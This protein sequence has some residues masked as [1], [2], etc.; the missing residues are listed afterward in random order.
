MKC[1]NCNYENDKAAKVCKKC[2]TDLKEKSNTKKGVNPLVIIIPVVAVL[3]LILVGVML[4]IS[5]PVKVYKNAVTKLG[6]GI[7]NK[8][9]EEGKYYTAKIKPTISGTGQKEIEKLVNKVSIEVGGSYNSK[10]KEMVVGL[11][12]KY[13]DKKFLN[14]TVQFQ[15]NKLYLFL[16][17]IIKSPIKMDMDQVDFDTENADSKAAK[18]IVNSYV[19]AINASIK[20]EYITKSTE[21]ITVNK[22]E[23]DVKVY[24]LTLNKDNYNEFKDSVEKKLLDDKEFI[25]A[26]AKV[27]D[28]KENKAK[29]EIKES[30]KNAKYDETISVKLYVNGMFNNKYVGYAVEEKD[31][32]VKVI[33]NKENNYDI[34]VK[35]QKVTVNAN[36]EVTESS[37]GS[38]I[39]GTGGA[40]EVTEI[41]ATEITEALDNIKKLDAY[42]DLNSDIKS[43]YKVDLGSLID[44]LKMSLSYGYM[45]LD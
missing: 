11:N 29:E 5:N 17:D 25:K 2:G 37:K 13:N 40:K 4:M 45:G 6:N 1:S 38:N 35:Y 30:F 31:A 20:D 14:A 39:K 24:K 22:K 34:T 18:A 16:D 26:Y 21:K 33:V 3:V 28:I 7:N 19:K 10:D 43:I 44:Y 9:D 27:N 12:T 42:S 32:I 36:V 15:E 41:S 23:Q 8:A